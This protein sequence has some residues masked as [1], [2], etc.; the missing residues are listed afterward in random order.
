MKDKTLGMMKLQNYFDNYD[1][2][3]MVDDRSR[4]NIPVELRNTI[5]DDSVEGAAERLNFLFINAEKIR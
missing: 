2:Y 4:A 1:H 5:Y 3:V